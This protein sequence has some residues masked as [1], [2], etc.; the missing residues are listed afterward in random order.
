MRGGA[1]GALAQY[2]AFVGVNSICLCGVGATHREECR[3]LCKYEQDKVLFE[4][5]WFVSETFC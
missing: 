2:G 1:G 4:R 5:R 3:R